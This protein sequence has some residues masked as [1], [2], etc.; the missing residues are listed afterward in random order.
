[1]ENNS[2][3]II[4]LGYVGLP[5]AIECC[6]AG[7]KVTGVDV[8]EN[9]LASIRKGKSYI[10]DVDS[11]EIARLL[12]TG[13]LTVSSDF[14]L[15]QKVQGISIC[16]PTPLRKTKD[17]DV[18]FVLAAAESISK[19][20][21]QGHIII[22]ESTV[23]PGATE[24]LVAPTLERSG[25]KA[26]SDF[27]LAFS[28]ERID[29]GNHTIQLKDIPKLVGGIN[30]VSTNHAVQLYQR[31]FNTVIP[32]A[33][34]RDAEMAKLLENTYRAVN[35][36]LVNELAMIAHSMGIDIWNVIDAAATKPFGYV[37]FY[38][39]PGWGGHCIPVDP[40][41]LSWRAKMDGLDAG[42][43]DHAVQINGRMPHYVVERVTH[44]LNEKGKPLHGSR[45]LLLG[46][47]YKRDVADIRE[48]PAVTI[49]SLLEQKHAIVSYHDP[50]ISNLVSDANVPYSSQALSTDLLASQDCVMITTDHTCFDYGTIVDNSSLVFDTRNSTRNINGVHPYVYRI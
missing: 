23:Y 16:V 46:V 21:C 31:I 14:E 22:L 35:I 10:D 25:L 9:K 47:A 5:L 40:V 32:M 39:G 6:R 42:F 27:Y 18:S 30:E 49:L 11:D 44:L 8:D 45:I 15:L 41:Y 28:P 12:D 48:S 38:P 2:I 3:G 37:P 26:G 33:S 20:L 50:Y 29:P 43:I 13:Q 17:P 1:L 7:L 36:G 19:I 24:S 4:G 34:S